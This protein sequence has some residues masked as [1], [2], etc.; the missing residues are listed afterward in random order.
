[1]KRVVITSS[2]ASILDLNKGLRPGHTYTEKDW[3]PISY[4][5]AAKKDAPGPV[6]Y[7]ASKKL[8]EKAAFDYVAEHNPNFNITTICPPMVYGPTAHTVSDLSKLNT[9]AA[10]IYHLM[11]GSQKEVPATSFYLWVDVRDVGEAHVR[12]YENPA[13]AGQRYL[14]TAGRYTFQQICNVLRK[15]FPER[16]HLT[17]EGNPNEPLPDTYDVDT[18]KIRTELGIK[19]RS[20]EESI[21]DMAVE[22]IQIEKQLGIKH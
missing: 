17:P 21:H 20:L 22:F 15:D 1:M 4:E 8:A 16:R 13:S 5:E 12:A 6:A 9:S 19:F 7:C 14:C 10:E 18:T 3:N 11:D 2:F